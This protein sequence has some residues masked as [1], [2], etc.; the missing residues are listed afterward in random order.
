MNLKMKKTGGIVII[1][2]SVLLYLMI[3][4]TVASK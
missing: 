4:K 3:L 2:I 1:S